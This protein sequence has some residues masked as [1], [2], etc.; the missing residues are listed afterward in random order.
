MEENLEILDKE[1]I[2]VLI[3]KTKK[4]KPYL[5]IL[6]STKRQI[7]MQRSQLKPILGISLCLTTSFYF[8]RKQLHHARSVYTVN[9]F[10]RNWDSVRIKF[11]YLVF[12]YEIRFSEKI[13][14]A[15]KFYVAAH[16]KV[17]LLRSNWRKGTTVNSS[18][19][20]ITALNMK[21]LIHCLSWRLDVTF[22]DMIVKGTVKW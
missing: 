4:I 22:F 5:K 10:Y 19:I 11:K 8:N 6:D 1:W 13:L 21:S 14:N 18:S 16:H 7:S 9:T 3:R 15:N 20:L 2:S 12:I 17:F